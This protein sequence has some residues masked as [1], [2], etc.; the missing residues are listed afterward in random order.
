MPRRASASER[1]GRVITASHGG[2][3]A[4]GAGVGRI[5]AD[6][7]RVAKWAT[8]KPYGTVAANLENVLTGSNM[9][10]VVSP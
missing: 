9:H 5:S 3:R 7:S 10:V 4:S 1:G 2:A 8:P 6:G